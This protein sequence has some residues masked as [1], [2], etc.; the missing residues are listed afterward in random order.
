MYH[1]PFG[2]DYVVSYLSIGLSG[3]FGMFL[4]DLANQVFL[5]VV[6]GAMLGVDQGQRFLRGWR[7]GRRQLQG[8][9]GRPRS[10]RAAMVGMVSGAAGGQCRDHR[11]FTI[12]FM[13]GRLPGPSCRCDRSDRLHGGQ[14]M[15][16]VMRARRRS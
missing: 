9:P 16:P 6:F 15:P 12:P 11:A 7:W 13:K 5:F 1:R 14:L 8:G 3:I 4:V 10:G 2:F